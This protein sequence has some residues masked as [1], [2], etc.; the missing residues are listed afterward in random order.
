MDLVLDVGNTRL[1][2]G[3]HDGLV[4]RGQGALLLTALDGLGEVLAGFDKVQRV[5]GANVAGSSVAG[6]IGA[7]LAARGLDAEWI[8]PE[9]EE[10]GR[11]HV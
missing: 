4:W 6:R 11:A 9:R 5:L 1:K 7:M 2:W 8:R 10:I 3:L